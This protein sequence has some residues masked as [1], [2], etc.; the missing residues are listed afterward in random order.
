M[1]IIKLTKGKE[2]IVD[3]DIFKKYG[4]LKW[5][6]SNKRGNQYARRTPDVYL[7]TLILKNDVTTTQAHF[8]NGNTLDCRKANLC[9]IP[10]A[11]K[12]SKYRG[13][14]V[15]YIGRLQTMGKAYQKAFNSE[16]EAAIWYNKKAKEFFGSK[17]KL[18]IIK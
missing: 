15:R 14:L 13:V 1:K 3:N 9:T 2:V 16:K 5:H 8:K 11:K 10:V 7:H 6:V 18:N 4:H 17:A 12:N